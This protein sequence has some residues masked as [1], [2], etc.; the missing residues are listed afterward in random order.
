MKILLLVLSCFL[1]WAEASFAGS[2]LDEYIKGKDN[3]MYAKPDYKTS[4]SID[5]HSSKPVQSNS[6]PSNDQF[7][8]GSEPKLYNNQQNN[9]NNIGGSPKK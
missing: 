9:F 5:L 6:K 7:N 4:P 2:L 8:T 3:S 1:L